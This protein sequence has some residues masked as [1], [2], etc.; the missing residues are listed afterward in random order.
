MSETT[1]NGRA[2]RKSLSAQL[3]R[4]DA[5]LDG[6]A[7]ALNDAV[8]DAV[9]QA[10]SVA[11]REAVQA[12][13]HE[14]LTSPDLLRALAAQVAPPPPAPEPAAAPEKRPSALRHLVE[15]ARRACAWAGGKVAAAG[16]WAG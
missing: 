8:A 9:K 15:R 7:D 10:V 13:L 1:V 12:A 4:L 3:D 6:L 14:V 16:G 11:A 2:Q 5:I